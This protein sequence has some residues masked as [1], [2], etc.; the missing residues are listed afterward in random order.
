MKKLLSDQTTFDLMNR[1]VTTRLLRRV[2][3][4][5]IFVAWRSLLLLVP[6]HP[7][8]LSL[9]Y[10]SAET[11]TF[12]PLTFRK[13]HYVEDLGNYG[14]FKIAR[15]ALGH[16][17]WTSHMLWPVAGSQACNCLSPSDLPCPLSPFGLAVLTKSFRVSILTAQG[18]RLD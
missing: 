4:S 6:I 18:G 7:Y 5:R 2:H 12:Q 17:N 14:F 15:S 16:S 1:I 3:Y 9:T 13:P 8:S 11:C 10:S